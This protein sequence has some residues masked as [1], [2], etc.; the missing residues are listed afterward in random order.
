VPVLHSFYQYGLVYMPHGENVILVL[1]EA[2][3]VRRVLFKDIAEEVAV[4]D[5][6]TPL[7]PRAERIHAE[8]AEELRV[9]SVFT[10][11]FDCFVRFLAAVLDGAGTVGESLFWAAV[12]ACAREYQQVN[13]H[14]ADRFAQ[15]DL[16][17]ERF[18][19]CCL[20][21]LQLRDNR[22]LVDRDVPAS[23]IQLAGTLENPVAK[24]RYR[25]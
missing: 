6:D 19:L 3:N 10:Y 12:G 2:G 22:Q 18:L 15:F 20:N 7:P 23:G 14:L 17:V 5:P 21:R 24:H 4:L 13:P 9:L 25:A 11:V 16:F 8:V 1:D